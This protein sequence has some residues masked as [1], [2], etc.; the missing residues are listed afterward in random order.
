MLGKCFR[1]E[2]LF[3]FAARAS[4]SLK[5]FFFFFLR[6]E[7]HVGAFLIFF[8]SHGIVLCDTDPGGGK[9]NTH[10]N[11]SIHGSPHSISCQLLEGSLI[12]CYS[13]T[14]LPVSFCHA[15]LGE[16][17]WEAFSKETKSCCEFCCEFSCI[18]PTKAD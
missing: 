15:C 17:F 16:K 1:L 7:S 6:K 9:E 8:L 10:R 14:K 2:C 12:S 11:V 18:F 5:P 4:W 3:I 13:D